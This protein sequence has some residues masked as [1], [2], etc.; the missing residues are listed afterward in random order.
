MCFYVTLDLFPVVSL[1]YFVYTGIV[2][3]VASMGGRVDLPQDL[4]FLFFIGDDFMADVYVWLN[5]H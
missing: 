2:A 1:G 4:F 3:T 5:V